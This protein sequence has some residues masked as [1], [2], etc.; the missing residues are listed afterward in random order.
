MKPTPSI[1]KF[2][3][4]RRSCD[5]VRMQHS[6]NDTCIR[7]NNDRFQQ[8]QKT[9]SPAIAPQKCPGTTVNMVSLDDCSKKIGQSV[10]IVCAVLQINPPTLVTTRKSSTQKMLA[11]I[12]V[13]DSTKSFVEVSVT[14][15]QTSF[16]QWP[17]SISASLW[18][19]YSFRE[20]TCSHTRRLHFGAK[21]LPWL[22]LHV[23]ATFCCSS[24]CMCSEL[25]AHNCVREHLPAW[26]SRYT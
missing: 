15:Q 13:A 7:T 11:K 8:M 2:H 10:N 5:C 12:L 9:K 25:I 17:V 23:S 18:F 26:M 20:T 4:S 22:R 1:S 3:T 24:V 14:E 16:F 6:P 21:K 19:H